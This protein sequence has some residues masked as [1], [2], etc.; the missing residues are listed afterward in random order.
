MNARPR[1]AL[2]AILSLI[3]AP[4]GAGA[5]GL[6]GKW[7]FET[8]GPTAP[9]VPV[10]QSG[11]TLSFSIGPF[12]F[13]GSLS[14]AGSFTTYSVSASSPVMAGINGRIMPSGNLLDGRGVVAP[15]L[16]GQLPTV[17]GLVARR[18]TCDDGNTTSGDGC[19]ATCQVEPCWSCTGDPSV[20]SPVAN[21]GAC[22]DGSVC[23]TDETC[24]AGSC[25]GGLPVSPCVDMSGRW[26]RQVEIPG[27]GVINNFPTDVAQDGTDVIL[28]GYVGTIDPATGAFD[29]RIPNTNL[30]CFIGFDPLIG[31]VAPS[32][33]TYSATGSVDRPRES[34]PDHC[35]R[36]PLTET[37]TRCGN[38]TIDLGEECDDG[39][40]GGGDCCS[41]TC[42]V[43]PD[44]PASCDGNACT[45]PDA[46]VG[47]VCV[48][49]T[50]Q[51]GAACTIC[52]GTCEN[53]GGVCSC[54]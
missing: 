41:A 37:A 50:C 33:L 14:A 15:F 1:G 24:T 35:D 31:S 40:T 13:A 20:C 23:T 4:H 54:R 45:R 12:A 38:G 47:G 7:H 27:L 22:E 36:F 18:C 16:P 29:L 32:G 10:T 5:L 48:P 17:S 3:L 2:V 21:G 53:E 42:Q 25:G 52:G 28:A 43:E 9:I 51:D 6:T 8:G 26:N 49:G 46:C 39:N 34:E 11:N 19:D 44:L 30:F